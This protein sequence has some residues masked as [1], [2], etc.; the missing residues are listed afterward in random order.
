MRRVHA[1]YL[2]YFFQRW[3][4]VNITHYGQSMKHV[5]SLQ[6]TSQN[7]RG[8]DKP[9]EQ[10]PFIY[11]L[12][13]SFAVAGMVC[14]SRRGHEEGPLR[15]SSAPQ[16]RCLQE[17]LRCLQ[18]WTGWLSTHFPAHNKDFRPPVTS[19]QE[20]EGNYIYTSFNLVQSPKSWAVPQWLPP[21]SPLIT[22]SLSVRTW[23]SI[24][25][26]LLRWIKQIINISGEYK[27][28]V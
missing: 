12:L 24:F 16:W 7:Q 19:L 14:N 11:S 15:V 17:N 25:A 10:N 22:N 13:L 6:K 8:W 27:T 3:H 23:G 1:S 20:L 2:W 9:L 5:D 26:R 18:R 28:A 21:S 4:K